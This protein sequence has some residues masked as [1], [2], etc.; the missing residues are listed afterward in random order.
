MNW[1]LNQQDNPLLMK[2]GKYIYELEIHET[3]ITFELKYE[4]SALS[5]TWNQPDFDDMTRESTLKE[6]SVS[7]LTKIKEIF[8]QICDVLKVKESCSWIWIEN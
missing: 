2:K 4:E 5:S 8:K 7:K 1:L 6:M 3:L